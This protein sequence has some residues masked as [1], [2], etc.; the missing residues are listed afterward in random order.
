MRILKVDFVSF[1]GYV[2]EIRM[3]LPFDQDAECGG[4]KIAIFGVFRRESG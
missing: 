2:I 1:S 3:I 4:Q